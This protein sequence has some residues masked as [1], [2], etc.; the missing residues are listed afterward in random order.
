M[1]VLLSTSVQAPASWP[2]TCESRKH[3]RLSAASRTQPDIIARHFDL[4][5]PAK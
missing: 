3:V 4:E 5:F 2:L 1:S